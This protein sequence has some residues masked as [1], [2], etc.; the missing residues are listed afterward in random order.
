MSAAEAL[1][2][3]WLGCCGSKQDSC[4]FGKSNTDQAPVMSVVQEGTCFELSRRWK[5]SKGNSCSS[6]KSNQAHVMLLQVCTNSSLWSICFMSAN[7]CSCK[8]DYRQ[9]EI[10]IIICRDEV[11]I[12]SLNKWITI[13]ASIWLQDFSVFLQNSAWD[14]LGWNQ[15]GLAK[16]VSVQSVG[17]GPL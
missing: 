10:N 12:F 1:S 7:R 17:N 5:G 6:G 8:W 16:D 13:L 3:E 11:F 2:Q 15:H 9:I 14:Q 4:N